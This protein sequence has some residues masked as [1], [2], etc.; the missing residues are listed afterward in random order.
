MMMVKFDFL[1]SENESEKGK[2]KEKKNE[3]K[4]KWVESDWDI[5]FSYI[6]YKI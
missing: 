3:R 6:L 5:W 4:K 1:S 2:R